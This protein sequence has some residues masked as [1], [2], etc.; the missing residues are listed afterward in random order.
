MEGYWGENAATFQKSCKYY[1]IRFQIDFEMGHTIVN[2]Y[3]VE[4]ACLCRQIV[5]MDHT[6]LRADLASSVTLNI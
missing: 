2:D 5:F 4:F 3:T 1:I 6:Y